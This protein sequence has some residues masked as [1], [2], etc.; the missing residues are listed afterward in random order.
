MRVIARTDV[1]RIVAY[2]MIIAELMT[3]P[4]H[5][6]VLRMR[7]GIDYA[8]HTYLC[9]FHLRSHVLHV[10]VITNQPDDGARMQEYI[11]S[12]IVNRRLL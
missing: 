1:R 11:I 2:V 3:S 4:V 12:A 10:V 9:P 5:E 6:C 8:N 7:T